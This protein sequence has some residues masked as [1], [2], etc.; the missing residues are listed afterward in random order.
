LIKPVIAWQI[1]VV[2]AAVLVMEGLCLA[3]VID[4]ITMPPPHEIARDLAVQLGA[5]TLYPAIGKTLGNVALSFALAVAAGAA[6]G[7]AL[8]GLRAVRE[9]LEPLFAAYYAVPVFA[10]YP[11]L[12]VAFGLGD[13]P[14]ILIGFLL[15]VVAVI[16]N[17]LIGLDR[18][19]A[20]LK[21]TA[22]ISRMGRVETALRVT[23]PCAAPHLLAGAKLALAYALIGVI[24]AEFLMSRGGM[25]YEISFAYANFDNATMYPLIVLIL[26]L[27]I[28]VNGILSRWEKAIMTRR[29][30]A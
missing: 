10:L 4:R 12:I 6:V 5:G 14:Q 26:A 13:G 8:H 18:V 24:G 25:G 29:G 15:G 17:T 11:L 20:V 7:A 27:S 3:G 1:A 2:A 28:A 21:K 16:V 22:R 9:V 23:L 30:L 19:P